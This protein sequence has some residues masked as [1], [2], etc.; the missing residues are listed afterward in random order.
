M[1]GVSDNAVECIKKM[2][3]STKFC[4]KCSGDQ[5]T[6]FVKQGRGVRQGCNLSCYLI[7]ILI[8]DIMDYISEGNVHAPITG[9]MS[10]PGLLFADS[11]AIESFTINGLQRGIDQIVKYCSDWNLICNLKKNKILVF[12]KGRKLKKQHVLYV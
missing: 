12:K 4:M 10:I 11:L 1:K 7:N 8:G 5:V 6:D 2:Y 3:N 9:K